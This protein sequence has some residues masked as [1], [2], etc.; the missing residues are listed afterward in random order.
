MSNLIHHDNSKVY[1]L[2][3]TRMNK[4]DLTNKE[5][6]IQGNLFDEEKANVRRYTLNNALRYLSTKELVTAYE[7]IQKAQEIK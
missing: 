3:V 7:T 1:S 5:N 2:M 4:V 6:T